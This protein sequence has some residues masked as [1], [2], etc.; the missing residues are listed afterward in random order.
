MKQ[1]KGG[2]GLCN[3]E[4]DL[5]KG[6]STV[7]FLMYCEPTEWSVPTNF[8]YILIIFSLFEKITPRY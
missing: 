2:V 7:V 3:A 4:K 8:R 5:P 1:K 6:N